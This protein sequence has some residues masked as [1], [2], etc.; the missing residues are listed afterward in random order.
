MTARTGSQVL[1]EAVGRLTAAEVPGA[2][3]DAR[4]LLSHALGIEAGRLT[5][6]LPEDVSADV[7]ATYAALVTRRCA[8]E[9]VSHLTGRRMF[10]GRDF[11]ITSD[12]L[13]P[14]PETEILIEAALSEPFEAVLDLGTGSGCILTTV[15]AETVGSRGVGVDLSMDALDVAEEN[16]RRHGVL[17]RAQVNRSYWFDDVVG[18]FDLILANPPYIADYEMEDLAPEVRLF[19]PRMAL[20]DEADGLEAYR[21]IFAGAAAHLAPDGR[22]IVEIGETQAADV[23]A[24]A[25][26]QGFDPIAVLRDLDRR[27]R[28]VVCKQAR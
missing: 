20:T 12:V 26:K 27:D 14:R 22:L 4:R 23:G 19:E 8:R 18:V 5:L 13:D 17:A 10:Y 16:L 15:L 2:A 6:A 7:E 28:V 3:Q 24:I 25:I 9:P 11:K 21:A 1:I